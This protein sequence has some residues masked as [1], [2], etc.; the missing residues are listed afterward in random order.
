MKHARG[1]TAAVRVRYTVAGL[2]IEVTDRGGSG[3]RGIGVPGAGGRGLIGMRE[4]VAVFGGRFEAGSVPGGFR[5]SA[6]LP[7][8]AAIAAVAPVGA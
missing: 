5:V 3:D 1:A 6:S 8:G 2:E 7:T 4:R